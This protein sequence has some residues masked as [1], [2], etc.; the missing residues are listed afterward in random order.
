VV[1]SACWPRIRKPSGAPPPNELAIRGLPFGSNGA[2]THAKRPTNSEL[3][4]IR[5][6]GPAS[7]LNSGFWLTRSPATN[8]AG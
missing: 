5:P 7:K 1:L 2:V 8:A 6:A 4:A 3:P